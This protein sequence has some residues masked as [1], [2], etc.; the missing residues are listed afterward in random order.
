M[1]YSSLVYLHYQTPH[2]STGSHPI[3]CLFTLIRC[4]LVNSLTTGELHSGYVR[5]LVCLTLKRTRPLDGLVLCTPPPPQSLQELI[6]ITHIPSYQNISQL[7]ESRGCTN[8][9]QTFA[10]MG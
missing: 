1:V 6:Y 5:L 8:A 3:H 10:G 2:Q 4:C 7:T 9:F